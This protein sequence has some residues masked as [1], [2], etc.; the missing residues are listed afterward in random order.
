MFDFRIRN[1]T[2]IS[3]SQIIT[4][5]VS[6]VNVTHFFKRLA[7][8]ELLQREEYKKE[9][10]GK[11]RKKWREWKKE[12]KK[13]EKWKERKKLKKQNKKEMKIYTWRLG[14]AFR[15]IS[16]EFNTFSIDSFVSNF[17]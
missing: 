5:V 3:F 4:L 15:K 14:E 7:E 11:D 13:K 17:E 6:N 9:I 10:S 1:H 12:G 8:H 16:F 2:N